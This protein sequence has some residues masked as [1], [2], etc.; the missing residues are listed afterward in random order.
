MKPDQVKFTLP[1]G[2]ECVKKYKDLKDYP[3]GI[4][5]PLP[6][7]VNKNKQGNINNI[8]WH[9]NNMPK[10][11]KISLNYISHPTDVLKIKIKFKNDN[12]VIKNYNYHVVNIDGETIFSSNKNMEFHKENNEYYLTLIINKPL[13]KFRYVIEWSYI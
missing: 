6:I 1:D 12:K 2:N 13:L 11:N 4:K 3:D 9:Y 5:I 7:T 10:D 8:E